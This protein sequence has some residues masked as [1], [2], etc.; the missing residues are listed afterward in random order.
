MIAQLKQQ[1]PPHRAE[2][3]GPHQPYGEFDEDDF[4]ALRLARSSRTARRMA[5]RL[6]VLLAFAVTAMTFAPWQQTVVGT[7]AVI[8]FS[9]SDRP[10]VVEAPVKGLI[11]S[12]EAGI[13]E[14]SR[15]TK[16]QL[17]YR[18]SDQDP[19]YLARLQT[20]VEG[21]RDQLLAAERRLGRAEE[22]AVASEA[23]VQAKRDE[24]ESTKNA[25]TEALSAANAYVAMAR[26]KL[27]AE[28]AAVTAAERSLWQIQ[29]DYDRKKRLADRGLEPP[30]KFQEVDAKRAA[31]KAKLEQQQNYVKAAANEVEGKLKER[32]SK[33]QEWQGKVDKVAS[34]L[35]KSEADAA[36]AHGDI[37]KNQEEI[38]KLGNELTKLQSQV[39]RQETQEVRAPR[40]GRVLSL[41]AL[42]GA[43][44]VKQGDP[45][46]TLVPETNA[47]AV[48]VMV[49]GNDVPFILKNDL[50][51]RARL[52]FDGWPGIQFS[53]WPSVAVGTFGGRVALVDQADDGKG[54]F[55][56]VIVPDPK[57]PNPWPDPRFLRQGVRANAYILLDIV[58]LWYEV[59]RRM[60]G[61]PPSLDA[62][63][64]KKTDEKPSKPPK[65]SF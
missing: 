45:L 41:A 22:S 13:R 26:N 3:G 39:A 56:V 35:A 64:E 21:L 62:I 36:K 30:M 16:G 23:V 29:L 15:V 55:R 14:N 27:D 18:I 57:D 47:L 52:Q 61:F 51:R 33:Q 5:W 58:P 37:A 20:Q 9:P 42:E 24:L 48:E 25:L 49:S 60:N 34:E 8:G 31:A 46:F 1:S 38:Q 43:K 65:A 19:N 40:D 10:Q 11:G 59:W 2:A 7:G 6:L 17:V 63:S 50:N 12:V 32:D 44:V 54:R 4:P 28:K 53:G